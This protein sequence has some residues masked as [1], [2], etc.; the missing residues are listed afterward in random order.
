MPIERILFPTRFRKL[1]FNALESLLVLKKAGLREVILCHVISR[2]EVG[3]VPYGGYLKEEEEK[4]REE[5]RIRFEDWQKSLSDKGIG[6][7]IIIEVGEPV[8]EILTI[9][10]EEKVDLVVVGRKKRIVTE[11]S[12]IGSHTMQIVSR[13]SIPI[14][15]SKYM[16]EFN[17]N[18]A[19]LTKINDHLFE[20]PLLAVDWSEQSQRSLEFLISLK[21]VVKK[22]L[23]F[24][25]LDV[26]ISKKHDKS[27]VCREE[28]ECRENLDAYCEKLKFSGINA[29]PHLGAGDVLQEI[30]R[31]SRE[32]NASMIII[33]TK[34]KDRLHEMLHGS[35]SHQ[36]AKMSELPTLLAP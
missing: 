6:S 20:M 24:H 23:I 22:A 12:F 30:L 29:E 31:F 16:V 15:A 9:A 25:N 7:K 33:G 34:S 8:H 3:F 27:C 18:G 17:W 10:E 21:G 19:A 32:R 36:V 26:K 1:A 4:I 2:K 11:K 28:K 35:V 14:L 5:V 13:S